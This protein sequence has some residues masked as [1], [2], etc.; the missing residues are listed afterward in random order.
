M[1]YTLS[2][3]I[4]LFGLGI[5]V[6]HAEDWP[7]WM[8]TK[9]DSIWRETGLLEKFPA[10]GVRVLWRTPVALGYAGPAVAHGAVYLLDYETKDDPTEGFDRVR[11]EGKER[12]HCLDATTGKPRWKVE[13]PCVY[14]LSY[15]GGPRCTPTIHDGKVYALGAM[16][17]LHCL[18]A[19]K[20]TILWKRDLCQDYKTE[21]PTWGFCGHPLVEGNKLICLVG[22]EG[23]V[24][25][26][27]DR[28]TGKE[29]WRSLKSAEPGYCPPTLIEAGGV[30]QVVIWHPT[31]INGLDPET[32]KVYWSVALRPMYSMSVAAPR[33]HGDYLYAAGIGGIS[34]LLRLAKDKPAV[35]E[36]WRGKAQTAVYPSNSPPFLEDGMIYGAC[37]DRG[38][39]RGV[40]LETGERLWETFA[41]TTGGKASPHGTAFLVKNGDRFFLMSETGHLVIARLSPK[42]YD[43]ISRAKLLEPTGKA[44][45][46]PRLW[47]HPAF[48]Q[49]CVFARNDK[50]IVC[51]SLAAEHGGK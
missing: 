2:I 29:L 14:D 41:P 49:K 4:A 38:Q 19:E 43:E 25:V 30:R 31:H 46:G 15:P 21:A 37:C 6:A 50:E 10:D 48:A 12:I 7:Q 16:G 24:A 26:A 27:F 35:E 22:G 42:G 11:L 33:Q 28:N 1:R 9:R 8:G 39:L 34:V 47:S 40:K 36:V 13:Y 23:S 17:H 3:G 44:L 45:G 5:T 18:D 32:G 51:V 20:G